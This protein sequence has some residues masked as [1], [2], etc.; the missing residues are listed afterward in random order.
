MSDPKQVGATN[1]TPTKRGFH[2]LSILLSMDFSVVVLFRHNFRA[3]HMTCIW[4]GGPSP[5]TMRRQ[6]ETYVGR[7]PGLDLTGVEWVNSAVL[8]NAVN[9][10]KC[11]RSHHD[12]EGRDYR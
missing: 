10:P 7:I 6:A 12:I 8:L 1:S 11:R 2:R 4:A 3:N 9:R 5:D